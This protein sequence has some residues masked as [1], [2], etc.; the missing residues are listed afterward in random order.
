M[1][2]KVKNYCEKNKLV[3]TGDRIV[4]G[5]SGGADS[6]C[7]LDLLCRMKE[8]YQLT[9][10][11]V[12]VHHGLRGA[13]A[14]EDEVFTK[15]LCEKLEVP[16]YCFHEEVKK[17]AEQEKISL[18]EAGRNCRYER[19]EEVRQTTNS[20]KIAVAHH[21]NDQA[22]TV[23]FHLVRGSGIEGLAGIRPIRGNIIRPMLCVTKK[24]VLQYLSERKLSY[25]IDESNDDLVYTRNQI[26]HTWIPMLEE[27]NP[28]AVQKI[29]KTASLVL[30]ASSYLHS[31]CEKVYR[32]VVTWQEM[33]GQCQIDRQALQ[34]EH[35]FIQT[36]VLKMA[37]AQVACKKE[38]MSARH[39]ESLQALLKANTGK[40]LSL[41]EKV[42]AW[43]EYNHLIL[44]RE[45]E[46]DIADVD[47]ELLELG[48]YELPEFGATLYLEVRN[49]QDNKIIS[50]DIYKKMFDYDKIKGDLHIRNRKKN[51]TVRL[52]EDGGRKSLKKYMIDEKIPQKD[53]KKYLFWQI[54]KMCC[55]S[56][57][58]E[59]E[60]VIK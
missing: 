19:L 20:T 40:K 22:E 38:D 39:I 24:E 9:I 16:L 6:V 4:V 45:K 13:S 1:Y 57:V 58:I 60:Q 28:L 44:Q 25:R 5:V 55:G 46:E 11:A 52:K 47:Y 41:P 42:T 34:K 54:G 8:S 18:E 32:E 2:Q 48:V 37:F 53:R 30:S 56:S 15:K 7:L 23:L 26:R 21:A 35:D 33:I 10:T 36:E 3:Q 51:D 43:T 29:A 59:W 31:Q 17:R 12:H 27:M 49:V 50:K 14:D